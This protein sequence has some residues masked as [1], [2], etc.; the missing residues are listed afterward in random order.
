[1]VLIERMNVQLRIDESELGRYLA[2]GFKEVKI[3]N[4]EIKE[5]EPIQEQLKEVEPIQEQLKEDKKKLK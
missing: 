2:E 1:M 3:P 4:K 5:V